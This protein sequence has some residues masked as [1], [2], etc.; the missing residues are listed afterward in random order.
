MVGKKPRDSRRRARGADAHGAE[1]PRQGTERS[2]A[3]PAPAGEGREIPSP[4][5]KERSAAPDPGLAA[6]PRA[7]RDIATGAEIRADEKDLAAGEIG[8]DEETGGEGETR[9]GVAYRAEKATATDPLA[10]VQRERDAIHDRWLRTVAELDNLRRRM[11]REVF[12]ARRFAE[13]ELLRRFL[14]VRDNL[15][16]ALQNMPV[17]EGAAGATAA[18]A[19]AENADAE[20]LAGLRTGVSLTLERFEALLQESGVAKIAALGETFDPAIHEAVGQREVEGAE[21]GT[22]VEVLQEGYALGDVVLRPSRVI[23]AS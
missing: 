11:R 14:E 12:D 16:R 5:R 3:E 10:E 8:A 9:A 21:S 23:I 2:V 15:D 13:A 22:V 20:R 6:E 19:G 18:A 17:G 1:E 4:A 7:A